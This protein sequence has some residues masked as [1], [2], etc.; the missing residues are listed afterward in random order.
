VLASNKSGAVN[1]IDEFSANFAKSADLLNSRGNFIPNALDNRGRAIQY[2]SD[3]LGNLQTEFGTGD[4]AQP[5]GQVAKA[6][7]A[8]ESTF[9]IA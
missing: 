6:L 8:Y 3:N 4:R 5:N 2:I 9:G 1:T 7:A